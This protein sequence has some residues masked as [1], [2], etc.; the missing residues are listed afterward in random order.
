MTKVVSVI[1]IKDGKILIGLRGDSGKWNLP[2]GHVEAGEELRAAAK[3]ELREETG[4]EVEAYSIWEVGF[5]DVKENLRVYSFLC[6]VTGDPDASKDPD[7]EMVAFKWVDPNKV[8]KSIMSNLHNKGDVSLQFMGVQERTLDLIWDEDGPTKR[9]L[10]HELTKADDERQNPLALETPAQREENLRIAKERI[11]INRLIASPNIND[12]EKALQSKLITPKQLQMLMLDPDPDLARDAINHPYA[13]PQM[14][15]WAEQALLHR[16]PPGEV[17]K[18]PDAKPE[19]LMRVLNTARNVDW[20][21]TLST[22]LPARIAHHPSFNA[23]LS[24]AVINHP[25]ANKNWQLMYAALHGGSGA[26]TLTSEDL[27]PLVQRATSFPDDE[28]TSGYRNVPVLGQRNIMSALFKHPNLSEDQAARLLLNGNDA[29]FGSGSRYDGPKTQEFLPALVKR[30][31]PPTLN[32]AVQQNLELLK[33][34][35]IFHK[36][37]NG[38]AFRQMVQNGRLDPNIVDQILEMNRTLGW[39]GDMRPHHLMFDLATNPHMTPAQLNK[40]LD[41]SYEAPDA[42]GRYNTAVRDALFQNPNLNETHLAR[43][44]HDPSEEIRSRAALSDKVTPEILDNV[45]NH[46]LS[47]QLGEVNWEVLRNPKI[48]NE[49]IG[50]II[51]SPQFLDNSHGSAQDYLM[52]NPNMPQDM[53]EKAVLKLG[54]GSRAWDSGI[55][56]DNPLWRPDMIGPL[57]RR[58]LAEGNP[59]DEVASSSNLAFGRYGRERDRSQPENHLSPDTVNA[60]LDTGAFSNALDHTQEGGFTPEQWKR[61]LTDETPHGYAGNSTATRAMHREDLPPEIRSDRIINSSNPETVLAALTRTAGTTPPPPDEIDNE[62][63]QAAFNNHA[64]NES[65]RNKVLVRAGKF[66][67]VKPE[68]MFEMMKLSPELAFERFHAAD[69]RITPEMVSWGLLHPDADVRATVLK[70]PLATDE[71]VQEALLDPHP[72]VQGAAIETGRLTPAQLQHIVQT[73]PHLASHAKE[74]L[75]AVSPDANF[76][77]KVGV[78]YGLAKIRKIRDQILASGKPALSPKELP[79][80]DWS[81]GRGKDGNIYADKLQEFIDKKPHDQVYNVSHTSW[82]GAQRHNQENSKVFQLSLTDDHMNKMSQAGVLDTFRRMQQAS[83]YSSHPVVKDHGIGWV[84]YTQSNAPVQNADCEQC[85]GAGTVE[86]KHEEDCPYCDGTGNDADASMDC[87]DCDGSGNVQDGEGNESECPN[88]EGHGNVHDDEAQCGNCE[89]NGKVY[90][91][92]TEECEHC[93]GTGKDS[94]ATHAF[95]PKPPDGKNGEFFIDEVQSDFGQSFVRQAAAQAAQQGMDADEAARKAQ[96]KYPEEHYKHISSILFGGKHTSEVLHEAFLQH[97]RDIG[98]HDAKV[99]IHTVASKSP[100]SLGK[101]LPTLCKTCGKPEEAH[102]PQW[103]VGHEYQTP[104][105]GEFL[106][107]TLPQGHPCAVPGCARGRADHMLIEPTN[108]K[109]EPG[110]E[111]NR[112]AAPGHFNVGY[113]DVPKKLGYEPAQYG[114]LKTQTGKQSRD[115]IGAGAPTWEGKVRK[116]EDEDLWEPLIKTDIH[117]PEFQKWFRGSKAVHPKDH[118]KA[119]QPKVFY[120]GQT[121]PGLGGRLDTLSFAHNPHVASVYSS[122]P[123]HFGPNTYEKGANVTPVYL[124]MRKPLSMPWHQATFHDVLSKLKYGDPKGITH[125]EAKGMLNHL[126]QRSMGRIKLPEFQYKFQDPETGD[127]DDTYNSI[128]NL[129]GGPLG[130]YADDWDVYDGDHTDAMNHAA[131]LWADTYAFVDAPQFRQAAK[132]LGYDGVEHRDV[133]SPHAIKDATGMDPEENDDDADKMDIGSD[134]NEISG[135]YDNDLTHSTYRPFDPHKQVM[136]IHA[137]PA[138]RSRIMQYG[139]Q[140]PPQSVLRDN[141]I[142]VKSAGRGWQPAFQNRN[143]NQVIVTPVFHNTDLLP[144]GEFTA[145]WVDGFVSP[146]GQFHTREETARKIKAQDSFQLPGNVQNHAQAVQQAAAEVPVP[147]PEPAPV[148]KSELDEIVGWLKSLRKDEPALNLLES[149]H[150]LDNAS[151]VALD[152][153]GWNP[154]VHSAFAAAKFLTGKA[155]VDPKLVRRALYECDGDYIEAAIKAYELP[156]DESSRKAIRAVQHI[157]S[158]EKSDIPAGGTSIEAGVPD[159][160]RTTEALRRAF[161]QHA[162]RVAH[163]N[164]KHSKGALIAK[165]PNEDRIYLLKPGSGGD[166]PA[167]GADQQPASQS[168]R[169][170]A[171]WHVAEDWGVGES[172]PRADLVIIDGQEVAA[173]HMLPFTWKNLQKKLGQNSAAVREALSPYRDRGILHKWAVLDFVLGNPDRHGENLMVSEDNRQVALIDHGSAFAGPAFDPAYDNNSFVPF[174]L[175][176]WSFAKFN[177]LTVPEKLKTMPQVSDRVRAQLSDWLNNLHADQLQAL[178]IRFGVDPRPSLDRLAKIKLMATELPVDEAIN[179]LWVTT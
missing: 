71:Q 94:E 50:R 113:H 129:R 96:E 87:P 73:M 63:R 95:E 52:R 55:M 58:S 27:E 125:D 108:H 160:D 166:S 37:H 153:L 11:Q 148:V 88:C 12:R 152:M 84:R 40:L 4:L 159:A 86:H 123:K 140:L 30:L 41:V 177:R 112:L 155:D 107:P 143:T 116:F 35:Q 136:P 51:D 2:G 15:E 147:A 151:D 21:S 72:G 117:S 7:E 149:D 76:E 146:E 26:D 97:L 33:K 128:I 75:R 162:V 118:P 121:Q 156:D 174:Y 137:G 38:A 62:V 145:E 67:S 101:E 104:R 132:R 178:L 25:E 23:D 78:R 19:D 6:H 161:A 47:K 141:K 110:G 92:E 13:T 109:Y 176:A 171:F 14:K 61:L 53:F 20:R 106:E 45:I 74:Q 16:M 31:S 150:D 90:S 44:I 130:S 46:N 142:L 81:M 83:H 89:G 175:R 28:D 18:R 133:L 17:V 36:A 114:S 64:L 154:I 120:R 100:I 70:H 119:G 93:S 54:M 163:L 49:Q 144:D 3:R 34:G 68:T 48:T 172:I 103:N 138:D 59:P 56:T 57:I 102:Q 66:R 65:D 39:T 122:T 173:L 9:E 157:A 131:K 29:H 1:A 85:D 42:S 170:V 82:D 43:M 8:P 69:H 77:Q 126:A 32:A 79:P 80:G 127:D 91:E 10:A 5:C 111:P 139:V 165:D 22:D 134:M 115:D 105:L 24:R 169:E 168:R 135:D 167:S 99:Q 164:G 158:L 98:H 124:R 179:K 60:L